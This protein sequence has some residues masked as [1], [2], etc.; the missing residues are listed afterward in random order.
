MACTRSAFAV[1]WLAILS[2][3]VGALATSE[4]L[5]PEYGPALKPLEG[6]ILVVTESN[7]DIIWDLRDDRTPDRADVVNLS[8]RGSSLSTPMVNVLKAWLAR[9]KGLVLYAGNHHDAV[10]NLVLFRPDLPGGNFSDA[11]KIAVAIPNSHPIVS[12]VGRVELFVQS[13]LDRTPEGAAVPVLEIDNGKA[14]AVALE[15]GG[16]RVLALATGGDRPFDASTYDNGVFRA[17]ALL[18][19]AGKPLPGSQVGAGG[20]AGGQPP[21]P[22]TDTVVLKNG[23][24]LRG[25][26]LDAVFALRASYADLS[27]KVA[28]VSQIVLEGAGANIEQVMLRTGDRVSGVLT[29]ATIRVRLISGTVVTIDKDKVKSVTFA[30][31]R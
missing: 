30:A 16:G 1:L 22:E 27:F 20:A 4:G 8:L 28:E 24:V 11:V 31:Q 5:P 23:D 17:R 15:F 25:Q 14:V 13:V 7:K 2:S 29:N 6:R 19:L 3:T 18:W 9:G 21:V 10:D 26:V 12:D